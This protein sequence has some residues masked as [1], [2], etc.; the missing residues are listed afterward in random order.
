M[1]TDHL[2]YPWP[3]FRFLD[4]LLRLIKDV[5]ICPGGVADAFHLLVFVKSDLLVRYRQTDTFVP[6]YP[7]R[8]DYERIDKEV[9]ELVHRSRTVVRTRDKQTIPTYFNFAAG[10]R[11]M[12]KGFRRWCRSCVSVPLSYRNML[13]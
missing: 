5:E 9:Q 12:S 1:P 6:C 10:A 11:D 8:E 3:G 2:S 4:K 7:S 13:D